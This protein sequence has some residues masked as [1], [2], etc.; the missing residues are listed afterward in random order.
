[1]YNLDKQFP[2]LKVYIDKLFDYHRRINDFRVYDRTR[3]VQYIN[4]ETNKNRDIRIKY[5]NNE[6][7]EKTAQSN[8]HRREKKNLFNKQ[9]ANTLVP[10]YEVAEIMLW[11]FHDDFK[12]VIE[13]KNRSYRA[14]FIKYI[15][16]FNKL[17]NDTNNSIKDLNV[18]FGYKP[19][20][21]IDSTSFEYIGFRF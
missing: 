10:I 12:N 20:D 1:M 21:V 5:I 11:S 3:V 17:I 16:I 19:S 7:D 18:K 9:L 4:D 14:I 8:L 13:D 2:D 6:Y 15:D